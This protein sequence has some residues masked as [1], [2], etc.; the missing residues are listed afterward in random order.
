MSPEWKNGTSIERFIDGVGYKAF[1]VHRGT[2]P[3]TLAYIRYLDDGKEELEVPIDE[4]KIIPSPS[5]EVLDIQFK[6][7]GLSWILSKVQCIS[8]KIT[9]PY[10][11]EGG[12]AP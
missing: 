9:H 10:I 6:V 11:L 1:V 12:G 5:N 4:C 7:S 3:T 2:V 8:S